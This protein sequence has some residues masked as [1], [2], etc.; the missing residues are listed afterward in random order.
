MKTLNGQEVLGQAVQIQWSLPSTLPP[1]T[2][3]FIKN[4]DATTKP[5]ELSA[6]FAEHGTI[7]SVKVGTNARG[8]GYGFVLFDGQEAAKAAMDAKDGSTFRGQKLY[9]DVRKRP[10]LSRDVVTVNTITTNT[11]LARKQLRGLPLE[12]RA[13]P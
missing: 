12:A 9:E 8:E 7:L 6:L 4:L 5:A 13:P 3:L 1:N 10:V 2:N 11:P